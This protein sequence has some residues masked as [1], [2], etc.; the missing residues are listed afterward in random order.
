MLL[1][2]YLTYL[3]ISYLCSRFNPLYCYTL[4]IIRIMTT[5]IKSSHTSKSAK[6]VKVRTSEKVQVNNVNMDM[7]KELAKGSCDGLGLSNGTMVL[8]S[9]PV[10]VGSSDVSKK[11]KG[12]SNYASQLDN[13]VVLETEGKGTAKGLLRSAISDAFRAPV[14]DDSEDRAFLSSRY[15]G[16]KLEKM[17][18][19][20]KLD[21]AKSHPAPAFSYEL[22]CTWIRENAANMWVNYCGLFPVDRLGVNPSAPVVW[23][24]TG[25]NNDM[26]TYSPVGDSPTLSDIITAVLSL[27]DYAQGMHEYTMHKNSALADGLTMLRKGVRL[28]SRADVVTDDIK[29]E[30]CNLVD[31]V[32]N[33]DNRKRARIETLRNEIAEKEIENA[34]ALLLG[35]SADIRM[36]SFCGGLSDY[37]LSLV[38]LRGWS[39]KRVNDTISDNNASIKQK[40]GEIASIE[41]ELQG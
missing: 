24:W 9:S 26:P 22:V 34:L 15:S 1:F 10:P 14:Y 23:S 2:C 16:D 8:S 37:E 40:L 7:A 36:R 38:G 20:A 28:L 35:R 12:R 5:M 29:K 17:L 27:A 39:P 25:N 13:S 6:G 3:Y 11:S 31:I 30:L 4:L 21:W 33:E 18:N 19:G 32:T 41:R